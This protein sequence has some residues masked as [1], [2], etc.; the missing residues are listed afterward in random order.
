MILCPG[1]CMLV[2]YTDSDSYSIGPKIFFSDFSIE[3][4]PKNKTG[5]ETWY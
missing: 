5:P 4:G 3:S 1:Y 2:C